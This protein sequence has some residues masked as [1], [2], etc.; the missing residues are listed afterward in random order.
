MQSY[1]PNPYTALA[2]YVFAAAHK[3]NIP[4]NTID[5]PGMSNIEEVAPGNF[6]I[7]LPAANA[8]PTH[9]AVCIYNSNTE[10]W[11]MTLPDGSALV[12]R[13]DGKDFIVV[14]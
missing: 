1:E 13:N 5:Y 3:A 10:L 12:V 8:A 4:V 6:L 14:G 7:T 9:L 2:V 11:H